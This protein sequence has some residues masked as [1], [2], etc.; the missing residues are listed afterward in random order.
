[1][2]RN[3]ALTTACSWFAG[4]LIVA[5]TAPL[6]AADTPQPLAGYYW[7]G[8]ASVTDPPADEARNT[9]FYLRLDG[10][11]ARD[12]YLA[13]PE[14]PQPDACLDD[15]SMTKQSSALSCTQTP[16]QTYVCSFAVDL[17]DHR[18]RPGSVC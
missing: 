7:L 9:H 16:E 8:G 10:D 11:A 17:R 6:A 12:L 5:L 1:L 3:A 15:G 2:T 13:M 4:L 18:L 14:S